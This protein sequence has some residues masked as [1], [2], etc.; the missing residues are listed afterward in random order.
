M[1]KTGFLLGLL[2]LSGCITVNGDYRIIVQDENGQDLLPK[3][4]LLAHGTGIYTFK[5]SL[6]TAFP[7]ATIRIYDLH[8]NEELK[9]ES[10]RKCR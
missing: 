8:T 5:N 4:K 2:L 10:P 7:K 9:G 3:A 6:C 1:K